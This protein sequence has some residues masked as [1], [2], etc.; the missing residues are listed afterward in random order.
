MLSIRKDLKKGEK[1]SLKN[2]KAIRP[3]K[4]LPTKYYEI[5]LGRRINRSVTKG[6]AIDWDLID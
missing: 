4:G 2:L 6:T 5:L 3:G 1:L